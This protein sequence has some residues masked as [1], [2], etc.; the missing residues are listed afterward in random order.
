MKLKE[1]NINGRYHSITIFEKG[2]FNWLIVLLVITFFVVTFQHW[3]MMPTEEKLNKDSYYN[4]KIISA[5]YNPIF[6]SEKEFWQKKNYQVSKFGS[7]LKMDHLVI[8]NH[9]PK[10]KSLGGGNYEIIGSYKIAFFS[11]K[12]DVTTYYRSQISMHP[13]RFLFLIDLNI[14]DPRTSKISYEEYQK[15]ENQWETE[16]KLLKSS[17]ENGVQEKIDQELN[18]YSEHKELEDTN[19]P[20]PFIGVWKSEKVI[21]VN[22]FSGDGQDVK[23]MIISFHNDDDFFDLTLEDTTYTYSYTIN[24]T[25]VYFDLN[26]KDG[27][28]LRYNSSYDEIIATF[29]DSDIIK[30]KFVRE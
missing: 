27:V 10:L 15:I 7:P 19:K 20:K 18:D 24:E 14:S 5:V 30:V 1:F 25:Y 9:Y 8:D 12:N 16:T 23:P 28:E 17:I 11:S 29:R 4:D 26:S 6:E 22:E 2:D 3:F 21:S 13:K